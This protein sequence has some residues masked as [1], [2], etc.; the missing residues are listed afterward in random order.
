MAVRVTQQATDNASLLPMLEEVER[1]CAERPRQ[2]LADSGFYSSAN[3][4]ACQ[5]RGMDAYIPDANLAGALSRGQ[6]LR[7]GYCH[8]THR[9][10][11][12]MRRKLRSAGGRRT[13]RK[14]Q[15]MVEPV[16]GSLKQ[17]RGMRQF[18]RRGLDSVG[19][20]LL[21]AALSYNLTRVHRLR[22]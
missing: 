2:V 14:R 6:P 3:L 20:E 8:V 15:A 18:W 17:Q 11:L 5:A 10:P 16:I 4:D 19:R 22:R 1:R 7:S 9:A 21:L 12:R 13:Y